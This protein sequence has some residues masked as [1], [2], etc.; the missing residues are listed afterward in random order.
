M[1]E[2]LKE[3]W[4]A[5]RNH[6]KGDG[7]FLKVH[8]TSK[9][10]EKKRSHFVM[11]WS[12]LP[13]KVFLTATACAGRY[14]FHFK[15]NINFRNVEPNIFK[16]ERKKFVLFIEKKILIFLVQLKLWCT[17]KPDLSTF[18]FSPVT[19]PEWVLSLPCYLATTNRSKQKKNATSVCAD[20]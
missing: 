12:E 6:Y 18:F 15:I 16:L 4:R 10:T 19:C 20:R 2:S 1:S 8:L 14:S 17:Y 11:R 13:H 5:E 7:A 3:R 9:R